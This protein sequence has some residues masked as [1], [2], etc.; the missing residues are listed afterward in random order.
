LKIRNDKITIRNMQHRPSDYEL[1]S[2]W[3]TDE[4]VLEFYE[5]RDNP[6]PADR[7]M[8]HYSLPALARENVVPCIIIYEDNEIG[9]IQFYPLS[10][11]HKPIFQI[12][13]T[14]GIF[15]IDLF[16]GETRY[17]NKNIGT[18]VLRTMLEYLFARERAKKIIIDP[19]TWNERAIR[20]YEKAGFRKIKILKEHELHE[21][22]KRDALLMEITRDEFFN[23]QP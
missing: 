18:K 20:C 9:Y 10:E 17:W 7:I 21:G 22:V 15:G 5:G 16:I 4:E 2:K 19:H 11:I 14:E 8:K 13:D 23:P 12:E 6:F 3:L 1:L